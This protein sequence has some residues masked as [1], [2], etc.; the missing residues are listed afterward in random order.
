MDTSELAFYPR[1][2][3]LARELLTGGGYTHPRSP[4]VTAALVNKYFGTT[5]TAGDVIRLASDP[6]PTK[7]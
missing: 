3:A 4:T 7:G 1:A 6:E 5:Y 2:R